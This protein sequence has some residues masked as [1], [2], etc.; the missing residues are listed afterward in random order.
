[1]HN[2]NE[3]D[4]HEGHFD[5]ENFDGEVHGGRWSFALG[6]LYTC[7]SDQVTTDIA[8]TINPK[9]R[10]RIYNTFPVVNAIDGNV[11]SAREN[12]FV[13][14]RDLHE[15]EMDMGTIDRQEGHGTTFY[16]LFRL[17][18]F[19]DMK[20]NSISTSFSASRGVAQNQ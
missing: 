2:D 8:Y 9:W 15:W 4:F 16:V 17:K 7:E 20:L 18:A 3:Y 10:L 11:N 12:E 13:L 14:T 1:M 5:S 19:P 6:N